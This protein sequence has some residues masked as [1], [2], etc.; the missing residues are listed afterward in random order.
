[1]NSYNYTY[2]VKYMCT[3]VYIYVPSGNQPHGWLENPRFLNGGFDRSEFITE[4]SIVQLIG[5]RENLQENPIF[6]GTIYGF[7]VRFSLFCQLE[8]FM[9]SSSPPSK[10][11]RRRKV[12]LASSACR[13]AT[14][15]ASPSSRALKVG[16]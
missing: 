2:T 11:T 3:Y 4:L 10:P 15:T 9:A 13:S 5:S 16:S 1:M 7:R 6:H 14:L 8:S 12:W